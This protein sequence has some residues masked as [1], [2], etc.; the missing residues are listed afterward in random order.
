M[1]RNDILGVLSSLVFAAVLFVAFGFAH[2]EDRPPPLAGYVPPVKTAP[3]VVVPVIVQAPRRRE[4]L[5]RLMFFTATTCSHCIPQRTA[6]GWMRDDPKNPWTMGDD[7]TYQIQVVDVDRRPD[8]KVK[9]RIG[10]IPVLVGIVDGRENDRINGTVTDTWKMAALVKVKPRVE[11]QAERQARKPYA[12]RYSGPAV[13]VSGMT[14]Y[15]HLT[16]D[17]GYT[18]QQLAGWSEAEMFDL[19]A[20]IHA[21]ERAGHRKPQVER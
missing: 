14:V 10:S 6:L 9:Y 4:Q 8:L 15:Q 21:A 3:A 5:N 16:R 20:D 17:H 11:R 12:R 2:G 13:G 1:N 7:E 19:H 18:P